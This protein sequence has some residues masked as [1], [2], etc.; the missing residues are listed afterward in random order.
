MKKK[1]CPQIQ[2]VWWQ[3]YLDNKESGQQA[4]SF[5]LFFIGLKSHN[6]L[7]L[8]KQGYRSYL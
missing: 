2:V 8:K 4:I 5:S 3:G 1:S 6:F 7:V